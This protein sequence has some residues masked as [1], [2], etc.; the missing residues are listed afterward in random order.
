MM[1]FPVPG[2]SVAES[3]PREPAGRPGERSSQGGSGRVVL[4]LLAALVAFC[5][6]GCDPLTL[7]KVT[8]TIFD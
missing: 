2:G 4:V 5:L 8:S 7:H 1:V 6:G 3:K